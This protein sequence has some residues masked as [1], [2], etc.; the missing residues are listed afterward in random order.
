MRST[1]SSQWSYLIMILTSPCR[2]LWHISRAESAA[3]TLPTKSRPYL[4]LGAGRFSYEDWSVWIMLLHRRVCSL[5]ERS[6]RAIL[7]S[8]GCLK[9]VVVVGLAGSRPC[10][11]ACLGGMAEVKS[12]LPQTRGEGVLGRHD[13]SWTVS[14]CNKT[15]AISTSFKLRAWF[16]FILG[17]V[18]CSHFTSVILGLRTYQSS[19]LFPNCATLLS[20]YYHY[21]S[22]ASPLS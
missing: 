21:H 15:N 9:E 1:I 4:W 18:G 19:Q 11:V 7:K 14:Y 17:N 5:E 22:N 12:D 13:H 8:E 6:G 16:I 2:V 20:I 10:C 3:H